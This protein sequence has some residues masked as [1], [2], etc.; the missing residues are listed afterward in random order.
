MLRRTFSFF[1]FLTL[2]V[3]A[4]A[5]LNIDSLKASLG[6][7]PRDSNRVKTLNRLAWNLRSIDPKM[8]MSYAMQSAKLAQEIHFEIG[9]GNAYN[10]IGVIHYRRGEYVEATKAHLQALTIRENI[11]DRE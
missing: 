2:A 8:A 4:A 7:S 10:T 11:G 1:I 5:Q 3:N 6:E 9:R